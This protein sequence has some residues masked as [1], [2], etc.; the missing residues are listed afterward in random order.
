MLDTKRR[1]QY[2]ELADLPLILELYEKGSQYQQVV[3]GKGWQFID[4]VRAETEIRENRLWKI[5][6]NG[7][8]ACIFSIVYSDPLL[9][10]ERNRD[11]AVYIHRIVTNPGFR[12]R[13]YVAGITDWAKRHAK[14]KGLRFVRL[15][16]W[17]DNEK[18]VSL[19]LKH[20]FSYVDSIELSDS[21]TI[22]RHYIG[23][24]ISLFQI[25]TSLTSLY[26]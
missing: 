6:E 20:G 4:T 22:P 5:V 18:L 14:V 16:T 11:A 2:A 19:Y 8:I 10:R 25:D 13:G 23:N 1:F 12:G 24:K 26:T 17:H 9:W 7:E 3:F 15:D 21:E